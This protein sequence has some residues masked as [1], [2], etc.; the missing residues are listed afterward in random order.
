[1]TRIGHCLGVYDRLAEQAL[2]QHLAGLV[3]EP[4]LDQVEDRAE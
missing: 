1:V 3:V 4:G 2:G